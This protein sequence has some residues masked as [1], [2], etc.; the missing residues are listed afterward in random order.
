MNPLQRLITKLKRISQVIRGYRHPQDPSARRGNSTA[1][2]QR[3]AGMEN[4]N[5]ILIDLVET[6]DFR[7]SFVL[8]RIAGI[9]GHYAG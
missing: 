8:A 7:S 3:R 9:R 4:L 6:F 1:R 2:R 5:P